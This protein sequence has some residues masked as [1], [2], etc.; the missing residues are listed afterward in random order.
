MRCDY[1]LRTRWC[2]VERPAGFVHYS[3]V[4]DDVALLEARSAGKNTPSEW[5]AI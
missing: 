2:A 3:H 4:S 1:V 5:R